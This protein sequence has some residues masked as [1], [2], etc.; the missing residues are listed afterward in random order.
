MTRWIVLDI[1][2]LECDLHSYVV[3]VFDAEATARGVAAACDTK[4]D[5]DSRRKFVAIELPEDGAINPEYEIDVPP[6][7]AVV[8]LRRNNP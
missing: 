8:R 5:Y 2:C 4:Y 7:T 1:G 3:G 6:T